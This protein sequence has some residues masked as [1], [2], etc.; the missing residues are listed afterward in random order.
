GWAGPEGH[1]ELGGE[2]GWEVPD[3]GRGLGESGGGGA[4]G[5]RGLCPGG[6]GASKSSGCCPGAQGAG[7]AVWAWPESWPRPQLQ[8]WARLREVRAAIAR[9]EAQ[10]DEVARGV[11]ELVA[12]H[13]KDALQTVRPRGW[14]GA[15]V[16]LAPTPRPSSWGGGGTRDARPRPLSP[17]QVPEYAALRA[18]G[19]QVR[20]QLQTLLAEEAALDER[21]YLKALQLPN[22][23]HP[24]APV[25]DESQARV[26]EVVGEKP[27]RGGTYGREGNFF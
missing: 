25:G 7:L 14:G 12:S 11:R 26:M 10:R 19:R 5:G 13:A 22:R 3:G 23:T 17:P 6:G 15:G 9:L 24:E 2:S 21:F 20:L 1:R 8:T 27:G 16:C 4:W 18:R